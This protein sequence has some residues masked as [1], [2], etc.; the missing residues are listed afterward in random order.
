MKLTP[1]LR[2]Q[3]ENE[4][5]NGFDCQIKLTNAQKLSLILTDNFYDYIKEHIKWPPVTIYI[6]KLSSIYW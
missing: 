2:G 1:K 5:K 4:A 6:S 3:L